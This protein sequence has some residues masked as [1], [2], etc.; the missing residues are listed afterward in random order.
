MIGQFNG[1]KRRMLQLDS[2]FQHELSHVTSEE[3]QL[4]WL[5]VMYRIES[6]DAYDTSHDTSH[7]NTS[8]EARHLLV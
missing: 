4:Y 2:V 3:T 8:F 6:V 7:C 1:N 5:A